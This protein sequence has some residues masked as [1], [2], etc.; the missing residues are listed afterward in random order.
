MG[1]VVEDLLD[2][3]LFDGA[4]AVHH[5]DPVGQFGDDAE[6]VGDHDDRRIELLLQV[7][8]QIEDLR[9]H[10]HIQSRRRLIGDQQF[11]IT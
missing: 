11:R 2:A 8:Q 9:L 1:G 4:P 5:H 10:R 3:A 7:P 6:V